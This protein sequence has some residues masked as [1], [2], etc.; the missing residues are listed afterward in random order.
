MKLTATAGGVIDKSPAIF[1]F[2]VSMDTLNLYTELNA[3]SLE[4]EFENRTDVIERHL[5]DL[6]ARARRSF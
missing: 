1:A 2:D 5:I 6:A 4:L 3:E